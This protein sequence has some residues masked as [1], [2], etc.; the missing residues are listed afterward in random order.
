MGML[1]ASMELPVIG[2]IR[3][4]VS[5]RADGRICTNR[6][7]GAVQ[8]G[9]SALAIF[10]DVQCGVFRTLSPPY[11]RDSNCEISGNPYKS[12]FA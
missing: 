4:E 9:Q 8:T 6:E 7:K 10:E 12:R 1:S 2:H 11:T 5:C 3:I